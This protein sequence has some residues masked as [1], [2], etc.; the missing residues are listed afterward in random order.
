MKFVAKNIETNQI[1]TKFG[2]K[3]KYRFTNGLDGKTYDAWKKNGIDFVE[4]FEFEATLSG[5]PYKGIDTVVWPS[6]NS[7]A[8]ASNEQL[9]RIESKLDQ[10]LSHGKS[11]KQ[12]VEIPYSDSPYPEDK[13]QTF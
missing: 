11:S 7:T 12:S 13:D 10:L 4:G 6:Q 5:R 3:L 2:P 9:N 8:P 1:Q